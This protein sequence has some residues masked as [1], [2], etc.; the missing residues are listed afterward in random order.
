MGSRLD[1]ELNIVF[2][3][4][5]RA[6]LISHIIIRC[7]HRL[8]VFEEEQCGENNI[9]T[10]RTAFESIER[11]CRH[12][13]TGF[14]DSRTVESI[15]MFHFLHNSHVDICASA[16]IVTMGCEYIALRTQ[17]GSHFGRNLFHE[18]IVESISGSGHR[19]TI[20]IYLDI[21]VVR[22]LEIEIIFRYAVGPFKSASDPYVTVG[23]VCGKERIAIGAESTFSVFPVAVHIISRLPVGSGLLKCIAT[24]PLTA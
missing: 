18:I 9:E 8:K 4:V 11:L 6:Y 19:N 24:A 1:I 14:L 10:D 16:V 7:A 21:V 17:C 2:G 3:L 20:D 23:P 15:V 5:E 22:I 13:G 12:D